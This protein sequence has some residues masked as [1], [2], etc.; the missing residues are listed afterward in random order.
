MKTVSLDTFHDKFMYKFKMQ[1]LNKGD[2]FLRVG[3][4]THSL[5]IVE[6][7]CL[8]VFT[9]F[10]GNEFIIERLPTG[11]VLNYRVVFT[12]DQMMV[13]IRAHQ[14]THILELHEDHFDNI[15]QDDPVFDKKIKFY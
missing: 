9:E 10:E 1:F 14:P 5:Y 8:E 6:Y 15:K 4:D 13:N 7:G 3:D 12:D 2:I 11:S